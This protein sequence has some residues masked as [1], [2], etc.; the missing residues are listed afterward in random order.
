MS[1]RRSADEELLAA[2]KEVLTGRLPAR[3][4]ILGALRAALSRTAPVPPDAAGAAKAIYTL[5][6]IDSE[7]ADLTYDSAGRRV[8]AAAER[9]SV[10]AVRTVTLESPT[11]IIELGFTGRVVVGQIVPVD[12]GA[13]PPGPSDLDVQTMGG[14]SARVPFD[15]LGRFEIEPV[16]AETFRLHCRVAHVPGVVTTV[17]I[18]R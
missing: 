13:G 8:P 11:T 5:R 1:N 15:E 6:D 4:G 14:E 3:Q 9:G 10:A 18:P 2:L 12:P 7:L 17:W 16:P